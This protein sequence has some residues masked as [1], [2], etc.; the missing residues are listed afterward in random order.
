MS[1]LTS[2]LAAHRHSQ[3]AATPVAP[4]IPQNPHFYNKQAHE[5]NSR[6]TANIRQPTTPPRTPQ[7]MPS[8]EPE[9]NGAGSKGPESATKPKSRGKNRAK[10]ATTTPAI[11]RVDRGTTPLRPAQ[12]VG[13][14]THSKP[15]STP[16]AV[17]YAGPTFHAS[18]APSALPM[19]SFYSKS[20]PESPSIKLSDPRADA[21]NASSTDSVTPPLV[22]ALITERRCEES[23]LDLFFNAD[24]AEKERARSANSASGPFQPPADSP[25]IGFKTPAPK[26]QGRTRTSHF[27]GGS[28]SSMFAMELDG[29]PGKPY[30]PAFSTPYNERINAARSTPSPLSSPTPNTSDQQKATERSEALKS[31]LLSGPKPISTNGPSNEVPYLGQKQPPPTQGVSQSVP[32]GF[33][34]SYAPPQPRHNGLPFYNDGTGLSNSMRNTPRSSGLRR[35]VTPTKTPIP[36]PERA[37]VSYQSPQTPSRNFKENSVSGRH[38]LGRN[39][40]PNQAPSGAVVSPSVTPSHAHNSDI[41]SMENSIRRMLNLEPATSSGVSNNGIPGASASGPN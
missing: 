28:G 38:V 41:T 1:A 5:S 37:A 35:E 36:T 19:P 9:R 7:K 21:G 3:S 2:Q 30:G 15:I 14:F 16:N 33:R 31:F 18:P 20:V 39:F 32:S 4:R 17:A 10:N 23:P 34:N 12:S 25:T 29:T 26:I 24:R 27:A 40:D 8:S 22:K 6:S 11:P 13:Q